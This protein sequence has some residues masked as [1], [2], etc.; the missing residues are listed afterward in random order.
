MSS[1]LALAL[2]PALSEL[3]PSSQPALAPE[4]D[5]DLT[6]DAP[7][8][9]ARLGPPSRANAKS[10]VDPTALPAHAH[11]TP[12][13]GSAPQWVKALNYNTLMHYGVGPPD[14]FGARVGRALRFTDVSVRRRAEEEGRRGGGEGGRLEATTTAEVGVTKRALHIIPIFRV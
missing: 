1:R 8:H 14:A 5:S 9:D 10:W 12:I 4:S 6:H 11:P 7:T 2:S 3:S 13:S